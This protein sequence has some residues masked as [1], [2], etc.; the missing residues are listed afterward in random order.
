MAYTVFTLAVR[1]I[2]AQIHF[3][4][5]VAS[6]TRAVSPVDEKCAGNL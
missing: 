1:L 2:S 5:L 3:Y 6:L 4:D